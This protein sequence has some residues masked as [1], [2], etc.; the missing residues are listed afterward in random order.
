[1]QSQNKLT[2]N[3]NEGKSVISKHIYGHFSEHLGHCIYGGFWVGEDSPI[4]N[5]RGIRNDV[6]KALKDIHIPNLRW[7]GGCFADEYHWM[8]GIGPRNQRPKMVNTHWGGVVEDNSFGTHEFLDLCEQLECEP[9]ICGNVGSGSVEEMSKW[10]EY[11]TFDGESPMSNLRKQ[12]GREE[13]WKVKFWG[14]GNE[15]WGCGGNMTPDFYADLYRRY[16]TYCRN[17]GD[18][19]LYRIAGGANSDDYNWSETLMKKV[20]RRMQAMSLHYYTVPKTWRDKGSATQFDEAEYFTTIEKTLFMD[21]LVSKHSAIMDKHDPEK[22]IALAP[23]EWGTWYNVEPGTNPGFL[24]QQNTMRDAIVAGV[25]LNIFNSH[26]DRVR[27]ANIAQTV[28]VLQAV[29]LTD[30]EKM[31]LT[32]TYWVFWLYKAHH[33]AALLPVTFVCNKYEI[34]GKKIDA[35][36]VSAS[37]DAAGKI[38]ISL[39]NI[40][41]NNSQ[42]IDCELLGISAKSVSGQIL[43]SE[44][45]NDCNTFDAPNTVAVKKFE[46]AKLAKGFLSMSLPSKSV[47]VLEIE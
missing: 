31:T 40:D 34:N 36:S 17:Y 6:V 47:V 13:P 18:N 43:T 7:P 21:E 2:V 26:C 32:P 44:K 12:N 30:K 28:N 10:V 14:V 46:G 22:H 8:D 16:A 41:P 3:A 38:H 1:M 9:Y 29:I 25:T 35:V 23:D 33:E 39:V 19:R 42:P 45:I 4:P 11:I 27:F 20:G 24:F 37:K 15:N 5:T